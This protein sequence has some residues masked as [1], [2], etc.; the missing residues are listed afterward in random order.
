MSRYSPSEVPDGA[1]TQTAHANTVSSLTLTVSSTRDTTP[2]RPHAAVMSTGK[3]TLA[4]LSGEASSQQGTGNPFFKRL[5]LS[6]RLQMLLAGNTTRC[7]LTAR[8]DDEGASQ[9]ES[10]KPTPHTPRARAQ[11][12]FPQNSSP[13]VGDPGRV[14]EG[15]PRGHQQ[16]EDHGQALGW[17]FPNPSHRISMGNFNPSPKVAIDQ[18]LHDSLHIHHSGGKTTSAP[19]VLKTEN[20]TC[21]LYTCTRIE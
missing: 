19:P 6:S 7:W 14:T 11:S 16:G 4:L 17:A 18:Q 5:Q 1:P 10:Q 2:N 20:K 3:W 12:P 15:L 21:H 8:P 9:T 13:S